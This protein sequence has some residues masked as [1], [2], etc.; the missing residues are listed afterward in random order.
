MATMRNTKNSRVKRGV[1]NQHTK[2]VTENHR[3]KRDG[4]EQTM[5][6]KAST[7]PKGDDQDYVLSRD[8]KER[9]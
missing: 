9:Q 4:Q 1:Q 6:R 2:R 7:G 3:E 5:K 8:A